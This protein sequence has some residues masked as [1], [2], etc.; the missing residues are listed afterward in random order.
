[1]HQR[2]ANGS[3]PLSVLCA[4]HDQVD[5]DSHRAQRFTQSHELS[6]AALQFRLNHQ[7]IEVGPWLGISARMGTEE[8]NPRIGG[9]LGQTTT[10]LSD[11][12]LIGHRIKLADDRDGLGDCFWLYSKRLPEAAKNLVPKL[13]PD[14]SKLSRTPW[15]GSS[16]TDWI[17][18]L[19]HLPAELLIPRSLVRIQ[20][21]AFASSVLA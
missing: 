15:T 20:P 21:G 19:R 8:D 12:V 16:F 18:S 1:V 7:Q 11:Q 3:P 10:S 9:S 2:P 4:D 13:V 5:R 14:S 17:R 6:A